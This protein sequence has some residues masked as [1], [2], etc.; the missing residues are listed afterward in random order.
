MR[1]I[2]PIPF[3]LLLSAVLLAPCALP[4]QPRGPVG[5]VRGTAVSYT[6]LD[7]YKRQGHDGDLQ[8]GH[9]H[10]PTIGGT[11]T[12]R[13]ATAGVLSC[14]PPRKGGA[15]SDAATVPFCS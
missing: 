5:S 6:H 11:R 1:T 13:G 7:V 4:A 15:A 9:H 3:R 10:T 12:T 8:C 2:Q 14:Q